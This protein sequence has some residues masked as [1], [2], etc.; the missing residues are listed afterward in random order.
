MNL[1]VGFSPRIV[2][3]SIQR[4]VAT[5]ENRRLPVSQVV[6]TRRVLLPEDARGLKPTAKLTRRDAP[7]PKLVLLTRHVA[8]LGAGARTIP[9]CARNTNKPRGSD[10]TSR[11]ARQVIRR[12]PPD[13]IPAGRRLRR[14]NPKRS[15]R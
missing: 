14:P 7:E 5:C 4:R 6:A 9:A 1:A 10:T 15:A 2:M 13:P 3:R 12:P 11:P 8:V